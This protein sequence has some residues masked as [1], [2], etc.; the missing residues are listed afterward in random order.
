MVEGFATPD[1]SLAI[2]AFVPTLEFQLPTGEEA[3]L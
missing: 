2:E 1:C 3:I